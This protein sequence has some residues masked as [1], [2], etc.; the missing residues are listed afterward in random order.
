MPNLVIYFRHKSQILG[1]SL[2]EDLKFF[3]TEMVVN[4]LW[5]FNTFDFTLPLR[6]KKIRDFIDTHFDSLEEFDIDID[7]KPVAFTK[8][9]L[10][11]TLFYIELQ[12]K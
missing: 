8:E 7:G 3:K 2:L 10:L 1:F 11:E 12:S 4:S 5:K 6:A 9:K